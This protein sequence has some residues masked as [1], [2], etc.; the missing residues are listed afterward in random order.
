MKNF[1]PILA[2][3]QNDLFD[4]G[5][6]L[7]MPFGG[8]YEETALRIIAPM[9]LRL[10]NEIDFLNADLEALTSFVLPGGS[11]ASA[12][13]HLCRTICRRA[14]RLA[15]ET[16]R[17]E[18]INPEAIKYLNRLSDLLFV[19]SRTVNDNGTKDILWIPGLNR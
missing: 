3:I 9:I 8:K 12:Y 4:L 13:L 18:E 14:E 10:E 16:S 17:T 7:S 1:D 6:D 2:R 11:A 19:M 5:S 15:V